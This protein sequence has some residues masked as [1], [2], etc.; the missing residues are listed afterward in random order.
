M[1]VL[2]EAYLKFVMTQTS[3]RL[4]LIFAL[5]L[6]MGSGALVYAQ[7]HDADISKIKPPTLQVEVGGKKT[8]DPVVKAP[9]PEGRFVVDYT[10]Q[11]GSKGS[12]DAAQGRDCLSIPWIGN[13]IVVW[14]KWLVSI[15]GILAVLVVMWAGILWMSSGGMPENI[16]TAKELIMGALSGMLLV[17]GSWVL[18]NTINPDLVSLKNIVVPWTRNISLKRNFCSNGGGA[19]CGG[20]VNPVTNERCITERKGSS[21]SD[22][23]LKGGSSGCCIGTQCSASSPGVCVQV[24]DASF[25]CI[26]AKIAGTILC[27]PGKTYAKNIELYGVCKIGDTI[28]EPELLSST[29]TYAGLQGQGVSECDTNKEYQTFSLVTTPAS[30]EKM[31]AFRRDCINQHGVP[32]AFLNVLVEI[33]PTPGFWGSFFA[34]NGPTWVLSKITDLF[35]GTAYWFAIG[36]DGKP[37]ERASLK[38]AS[39]GKLDAAGKNVV[40]SNDNIKEFFNDITSFNPINIEQI[41]QGT[42]VKIKLRY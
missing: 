21:I 31:N 35:N 15:I 36:Q 5:L 16:N 34:A 39:Q 37:F 30:F 26:D 9:C 1:L 25:R 13:I 11:D 3:R 23:C 22:C 42:R 18:L 12:F 8:L 2:D 7:S 41:N 28:A 19:P 17:L 24:E 32:S 20:L 10:K 27:D 4:F 40:I 38:G 29:T 33:S 14:Y 6:G